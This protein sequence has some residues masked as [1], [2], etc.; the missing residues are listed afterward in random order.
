MGSL[1]K[2]EV[3]ELMGVVKKMME[4]QMRAR[5]Q[6]GVS[7][8]GVEKDPMGVF[9]RVQK[10]WLIGIARE[11]KGESQTRGLEGGVRRE[12]CHRR[13]GTQSHPYEDHLMEYSRDL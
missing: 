10:R 9:I 1:S 3:R 6:V 2:E 4:A 5:G 7:F 11:A 13:K 12:M 8:E